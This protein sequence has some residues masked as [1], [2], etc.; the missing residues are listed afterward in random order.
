MHLLSQA[1]FPYSSAAFRIHPT[2]RPECPS[3]PCS[4]YNIALAVSPTT[5]SIVPYYSCARVILLR[6]AVNFFRHP[7]LLGSVPLTFR[8]TR[9]LDADHYAASSVLCQ[10]S[11]GR[12]PSGL[13]DARLRIPFPL[14][15]APCTPDMPP[16][17]LNGITFFVTGFHW[18]H[19]LL[20][21]GLSILASNLAA[22]FP[23]S[24]CMSS[25]IPF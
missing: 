3:F 25:F 4:P 21:V 19:Q 7:L 18:G 9:R 12:V 24:A 1:L 6:A 15:L 22:I 20:M 11:L 5:V 2:S 23:F 14:R 8:S 13:P 10:V 16:S 17:L